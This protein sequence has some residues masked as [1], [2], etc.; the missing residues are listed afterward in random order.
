MA[1]RLSSS[2]FKASGSLRFLNDWKYELGKEIL[3]PFG[4][5]QLCEFIRF[6]H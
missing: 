5:Q 2:S 1:D 3:T 6:E 4:R